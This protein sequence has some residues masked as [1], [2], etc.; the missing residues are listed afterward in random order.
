MGIFSTA[1]AL[2]SNGGVGQQESPPESRSGDEAEAKSTILVIDDDPELLDT[3]KSM[4]VRRGFNVLTSASAP[5]G[6]DMLHY[7]ASDI[8]VVVLDYNMP[9]L[10]G[11]ETLNFI[12]RLSPNAKIIG[13]TATDPDSMTLG[14]L[15]GIDILL[16]KPVPAS[17]LIAAVDEL[18]GNGLTT[19]SATQ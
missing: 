14:Y 18:L 5:K 6:L 16:A 1:I 3:V 10:D 17:T 13:L 2:F 19:S 15:D 12:K 9:K 8:R 11:N 7:A 4:L